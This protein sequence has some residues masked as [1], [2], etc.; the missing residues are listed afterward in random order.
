[1]PQLSSLQ[2]YRQSAT[3]GTGLHLVG[4]TGIALGRPADD[5]A[6]AVWQDVDAVLDCSLEPFSRCPHLPQHFIICSDIHQCKQ[7]ACSMTFQCGK[8]LIS[9]RCCSSVDQQGSAAE[10]G[11]EESG[12]FLHLP[13]K[14]SKH[15]RH[16][17]Q[18][19][20]SSALVFA[21]SHLQQHRKVLVQCSGGELPCHECL[22]AKLL[23]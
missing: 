20:M 14:D 17:L 16:D 18:T 10:H 15:A 13:I 8:L 1:M 22:S 3:A 7:A 23:H 2:S 19:K 6:S 11:A 9:S 12:R 4:N 21:S 5:R